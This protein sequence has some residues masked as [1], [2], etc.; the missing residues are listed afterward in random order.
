MNGGQLYASSRGLVEA[1]LRHQPAFE[2]LLGD[3]AA[4][5]HIKRNCHIKLQLDQFIAD[6]VINEG[7]YRAC[8]LPPTYASHCWVAA[9]LSARRGGGFRPSQ[10]ASSI[11][12]PDRR[13]SYHANC[14]GNASRKANVMRLAS[15]RFDAGK[16]IPGQELMY[17]KQQVAS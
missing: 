4:R 9:T 17:L 5:F 12:S 16:V 15:V 11:P 7:N 6:Q 13:V 2:L 8:S 10:A 14:G 3:G 1:V